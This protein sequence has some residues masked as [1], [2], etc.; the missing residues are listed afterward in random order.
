MAAQTKS[1]PRKAWNG[2]TLGAAMTEAARRTEAAI[3]AGCERCPSCHGHGLVDALTICP[4]CGAAGF[5][6]PPEGMPRAADQPA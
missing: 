1:H 5:L 2:G 4:R 3:A 6:A